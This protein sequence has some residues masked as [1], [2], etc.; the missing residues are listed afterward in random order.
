MSTSL[1]YFQV[2]GNYFDVENPDI[3][4][5]SNATL[6]Q[7]ITG[8]VTFY[9]RVPQG[10]VAYI[11]DLDLQTDPDS[12][13]DAALALAPIQ[14]RILSGQLQT[15]NRADTPNIY[16]LSNTS[17]L[18]SQLADI[19]TL[20]P[21]WLNQNNLTPGQLIYDVKYTAVTYAEHTN[22]IG[23]FAFEAPT[24]STPICLTDHELPRLTYGGP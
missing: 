19:N 10:F 2:S 9:P 13:A 7:I 23:G 24:D 17:P 16:L 15:V 3:N 6:F 21:D 4:S 1:S 11:A 14:A 5:T 12:S 18:S 20:F 22:P 8:V